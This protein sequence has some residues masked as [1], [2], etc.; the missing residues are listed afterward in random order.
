MEQYYNHICPI[1]PTTTIS[2]IGQTF[3]FV[4]L[5]QSPALTYFL[6][7]SGEAVVW[8]MSPLILSDEWPKIRS[9]TSVKH[10]T[11]WTRQLNNSCFDLGARIK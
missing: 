2:M 5:K 7:R 8:S 1:V 3:L 11:T 10:I 9:H 4:N 6:R